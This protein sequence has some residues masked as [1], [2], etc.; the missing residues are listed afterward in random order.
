MAM[1]LTVLSGLLLELWLS[2][3]VIPNTPIEFH[4]F[5]ALTFGNCI[6]PCPRLHRHYS[7]A[8][9]YAKLVL[10]QIDSPCQFIC[11]IFSQSWAYYLQCIAANS[12]AVFQHHPNSIHRCWRS[13][14]RCI[15]SGLIAVC[16]TCPYFIEPNI[17][18]FRIISAATELVNRVPFE[19]VLNLCCNACCQLCLNISNSLIRT[20]ARFANS[21]MSTG[22]SP[23]SKLCRMRLRYQ[24]RSYAFIS[25]VAVSQVLM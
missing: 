6:G 15:R 14:V 3:F 20:P 4:G 17:S 16:I 25:A 21:S 11:R 24:P 8:A 19:H 12:G 13:I 7:L 9:Q 10:C 22:R 23:L 18:R 5:L 2:I 1:S